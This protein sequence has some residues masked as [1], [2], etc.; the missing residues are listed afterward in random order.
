MTVEVRLETLRM[1]RR[2]VDVRLKMAAECF[3]DRA[4]ESGKRWQALM[5][6]RK[7]DRGARTEQLVGARQINPA[8]WLGE[9]NSP[10]A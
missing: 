3:L 10:P 6:L 9:T 7:G 1:R 4:A 8:R 5:Q 2:K